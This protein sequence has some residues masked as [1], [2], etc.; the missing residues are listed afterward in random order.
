VKFLNGSFEANIIYKAAVKEEKEW[1]RD[2]SA[3]D[4]AIMDQLLKQVRKL[5]YDYRYFAD[6]TNRENADKEFLELLLEYIG[7]FQD[8]YFSSAIVD[9]VG[10]NGNISATNVILN[11]YMKLS[12]DNKCEYA[13]YYDN[14]LSRIKDKRY[15][16]DYM[17]LLKVPEDAIKLPLTMIML[18]KWNLEQAKTHFLE[19]LDADILYR[20]EKISDLI[21]I[22]LEALSYYKDT[23][24][25]IMSAF[26]KKLNTGDKDLLRAVQKAI[27][28]LKKR[29][30]NTGDGSV[31]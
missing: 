2:A 3:C 27:K 11:D 1:R 17:E 6:I 31:C 5:G 4:I 8:N 16:S 18:G 13:A 30:T 7:R 19:Y 14:A 26:E 20:N 9:V 22:S 29:N 23:D 15:L 10:K 25:I 12:D 21:Y 28:R 24:G